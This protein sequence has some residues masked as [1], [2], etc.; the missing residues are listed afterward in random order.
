[1]SIFPIAGFQF[2]PLVGSFMQT[3]FTL[4]ETGHL[5]A[6]TRTWTELFHKDFTGSV[7][8]VLVDE[9]GREL[10]AS[11]EREYNVAGKCL[12]KHERRDEWS[13]RVPQEV[14]SQVLGY[15]IIHQHAPENRSVHLLMSEE[16]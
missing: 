11:R 16:G 14:L 4:H 10:W 8:V 1:M 5:E 15:A 2:T 6:L 3:S 13:D 12:G 9:N 7:S